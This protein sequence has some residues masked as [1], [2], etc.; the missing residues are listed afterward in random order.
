M[1][2]LLILSLVALQPR[3][4]LD[5]TEEVGLG[6]VAATRLCFLDLNRDGYSDLVVD[7]HRVF[8]NVAQ[9]GTGAQLARRFRELPLEEV[10]LPEPVDGGPV[11]F[12][13]LDNDGILD[14]LIT[15]YVDRLN[16]KWEDHG[17]RTA[18]C[19]GLG[20]GRFWPEQPLEAAPPATTSAVSIADWNLDG[21]LDVYLGNWYRHYG[22]TYEGFANDLILQTDQGWERLVPVE[23]GIQVRDEADA[24]GRPTYGVLAAHLRLPAEAGRPDLLDLNYGRRWNRLWSWLDREERLLDL[25]SLVGFD[26]DEVRHGRYP[27]WLKER[28]KTDARFDRPDEESFRANGNTFDADI[29]DVDNDG[30]FDLLLTEITHGWAGESSDRSRILFSRLVE[31]G[32]LDLRSRPEFS[33][34]RFPPDQNSWNQGDLFGALYDYDQDGYLDVLLSSGDYPD[35]QRLRLYRNNSGREL[36]ELS[37]E[38]GIDHDGS[39]QLSLGDIDGDGALDVAVGQSFFRY[40][41]EM[42]A[43]REPRLKILLNRAANGNAL[44]LRLEGDPRKGVNRDALGAIVEVEVGERRLVRQLAP[45]GGHAGKQMDFIVHFGLATAAHVDRLLIRWPGAAEPSI[46]E[47]LE[48]GYYR[49]RQGA[50]PI[51]LPLDVSK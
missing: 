24:A 49:L 34:D 12:A 28:A 17:R 18:W 42:K 33:L 27:D 38:L 14:A 5:V 36:L 46:Y 50:Q 1:V 40:T 23:S 43:G 26:G 2:A 41:A 48:A 30:D 31:A 4:F 35:D 20:D 47:N 15:R 16:P 37:S 39:Q 9:E 6:D 19:K 44:A 45:I 3:E 11:V 8:L 51:E 32:R 13:D 22:E 29:G 10:G 7:R 21:R 25:G